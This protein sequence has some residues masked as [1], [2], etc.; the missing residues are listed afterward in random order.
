VH[1]NEK[2]EGIQKVD[3]Q[4]NADIA[5]ISANL[6]TVQ[7]TFDQANR[8]ENPLGIARDGL[9]FDI[10]PTFLEVG[11]TAQIGTRAVQGLM[12][13]DQIFER[14]L[15]MLEHGVAV[16]NYA[17]ESR[18][19]VRAVANNE[20]EFRNSVFQ[21][22]LAYRNDL[23]RLFGKPYDGT[24]GPGKVYPAGYDGPDLLLYMYA[25][26][27][28]ITDATVPGPVASY[29]T[30]GSNKV[31]L[32]TSDVYKAFEDGQGNASGARGTLA[33]IDSIPKYLQSYLTE[34]TRRLFAPTFV[35]PS[36]GGTTPIL[37]KDGLYAVNYTDLETP[38]VPLDKLTQLMP[39]TAAG[40]TFQAPREWGS[41]LAAGELQLQ[42]NKMIQQEAQVAVAI[43]AYDA[44]QGAI[45]R[46]MRF[47]NARLD[48]MASLREKKE[49]FGRI[50]AV[51]LSLLT[52]IDAVIDAVELGKDTV[53]E[54]VTATL[55]SLPT[56]LPTVGLAVSPGDALAPVKGGGYLAS[57]A[58]TTGLGAG[59]VG[60]KVVKAIAETA[61]AIADY[62]MALGEMQE[63]DA[64][65][66]KEMLKNLENLV[67]DEPIRR[68]QI[69]KELQTLRELSDQ[70]R[71]MLDEGTRLIDER[72][73]FNKRVAA[74][75]QRGRYQDMTFRVSRN[76]ALQ[77]Y[78]AAFDLTA[79]YAYLAAK[80]YDYE[81][82]YDPDHPGSSRDILEGIVRA[83]TLGRLDGEPRL[84]AG[85]LSEELA[86]LKQNYEV[87]KSQL[88]MKIPQIEIGKISLRT[89][90]YRILP[91][92]YPSDEIPEPDP[93]VQPNEIGFPSPGE[94]S[95][96]L[97]KE[98]LKSAQVKDLWMVPEYRY[99]CRPFNSEQDTA[100]HH[101][102]EPGIVLRFS[103]R[104]Q[105]GKNF[106]GHPLAGGDQV[107]DP[108]SY[109]TKIQSVGVWFSD[110]LSSDVLAD[111]PA[112]PRVYLVPVGTDIM[113]VPSSSDPDVVRIWNVVDQHIPAPF[114]ATRSQLEARNWIP[115]L[116]GLNGRLGESRKYSMFRAYHDGGSAVNNDELVF[117]TR[118]IARSIWN[119]QW[120][121]IIP[122]RMLNADPEEGLKRF[123][124]QVSDIKLVFRTYGLSGG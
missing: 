20:A 37:A 16:W 54:T 32:S 94:L 58:V 59:I 89:E 88:G 95:D 80:A 39:V 55:S 108:S 44:L 75:T 119:T 121:L 40:Y 65:T 63:Q 82:N 101:V 56:Y 30:F 123:T 17:N 81:T 5:V 117:D 12:H 86:K 50:Q 31:A 57:V 73:A 26:V 45:L 111:L 46:E 106:F 22:D 52:G 34:D 14:A 118:L 29:G 84:G 2:L 90:K 120:L 15:K 9:V 97:W 10:D 41:R 23:I 69:F 6:N 35:D 103:S 42:I 48:M 13:F 99:Y 21:E 51:T 85:G 1:P 71:A 78:R 67:G 3:R 64:V 70:Y 116:D 115:L 113:S 105:A 114:A 66:A 19:H 124:D 72:A 79:K 83:R 38:K 93:A 91:K 110:Y 25:D 43:G 74:Q 100:G 49:V 96:D 47:V 33:D 4:S 109:A 53:T 27:R 122:G 36:G 77:T 11:S 98:T 61:F 76:H 107:Y 112:T 68:I 18:N 104:I 87:V 24:I 62:E 7:T 28:E 8:G 60:F 102:E 92:V